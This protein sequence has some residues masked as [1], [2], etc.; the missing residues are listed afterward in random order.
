MAILTN[1]VSIDL[2]VN[3][4][5]NS[6]KSLAGVWLGEGDSCVYEPKGDPRKVD[7]AL[8]ILDNFCKPA[9]FLLGHNIIHFDLPHLENVKK[10]LR[11]LKKPVIDTLWLNPLAFPEHPYHRLVKH[12]QDGR[13]QGDQ[14]N[15][16]ELDARLTLKVLGNQL[17]EFAKLNVKSPYSLIAYHYLATQEVAH[18]GFDAVF[19]HIRET[20]QPNDQET[21]TAA[22]MRLQDKAGRTSKQEAVDSTSVLLQVKSGRPSKQEAVAAITELLQ[23]KACNQQIELAIQ[24]ID[25][26]GWPLAF[27]LAWIS[28]SGGNSVLAPWVLHQFPEA[29]KVIR[30]L[31]D[32]SCND[33]AC[34][35]CGQHNNPNTLLKDWFGFDSFRPMPATNDG[36]PLQ[37][38]ITRDTI[39]KESILG[40]LP[41]GTGKSV[42]YQLPALAQNLKTGALTVVISPLVA[43]MEDQVKG[44]K[45]EGITSC[46]TING[47]LSL[48]ERQ[49]ELEKVMLGDVAILLISPEQLRSPSVRKALKQR[50][51]GYWV[52]DEAHCISKW[53]HDFRPD[54]RY[55][56]RFIKEFASDEIAPVLCLTATAKPE[57]IREITDH[58]QDKLRVGLKLHDGGALREKL[59]FEVVP[60]QEPAKHDTVASY[61]SD[62]LPDHDHS[63]AIVYCSTRKN[64][65]R[66]AAFLKEQGVAADH[67]HAG[68]LPE[69]KRDVQ[70]QFA[71]GVLRVIAATNAF[72]MGINKPDI[73]LVVH[74]DIPASLENYMQEAG[75]A[76]RD[77]EEARC[78]LLFNREDIERQF[79]LTASSKL[80][81]VEISAILKA[82]RQLD[83]KKGKSGEVVATA[84]E[85]VREEKDHEF[86]RDS[87]AHDSRDTIST[88][89]K[90]AVAWLEEAALLQREENITSV[91]PACLSVQTLEEAKTIIE[92][93]AG[94]TD[95]YKRKLKRLVRELINAPKDE[96][97]TTDDLGGRA[98]FEAVALRRAMNDLEALGIATNDT[99]ITIFVHVGVADSSQA[100]LKEFNNMEVSL[101]AKMQELAPDMQVNSKSP[102]M[103]N[104]RVASQALKD[105]GIAKARPDIV[106]R[107]IRGIAAD[108][109]DASDS[110][111]SLQVK[112]INREVMDITLGRS[113]TKLAKTAEIR[114]NACA[115]LLNH[116]EA[117][118]APGQQGKDIQVPTTLGE[119][120]AAISN[121]T[122]LGDIKDPN[123]LMD[124]ALLWLH[125]QQIVTL[126][127]GL[128]VFRPAMTLQLESKNR[129]FKEEDYKPL[130]LHYE[131]QTLHIHVMAAY[132]KR[133]I[134]S[135]PD[136]EKLTQDY[137][138]LSQ[139][140][141]LKKW[142]PTQDKELKRQT[143]P[144]SWR[145]IVESLN[146]KVQQQIVT[147]DRTDTNTLVLAGPGSGKTRVLVH[148]I[149]Y[150]IR[151]KREDPRGILALVYNRH[152]AAE[153]R[154]RLHDLIGDDSRGVDIFTCHGFAMR[155]V[156][157]TFAQ[158][159]DLPMDADFNAIM[160]EAVTL[161]N[162]DGL[163][164]DD[165]E[166]QR[167]TLLQG[168][169]WIL[170]DE[171][172]DIAEQEYNLIAAIAGRT[173]D[174]P[175]LKLSLMAVGDDDQNIYS[176]KGASA[177]Y[178]RRFEEDYLTKQKDREP[179]YL[180]ENYRSTANIIR[181]SNLVIE[182]AIQRMKADHEIKVNK[183]RKRDPSGG[184]LQK[185]DS[186]GKGR[187]QILKDAGDSVGQT[188]LAFD[189]LVRLSKLMPDWDWAKTAVIAREWKYLNPVR[190]LC[191]AR[192]IPV[193]SAG[194]EKLNFWRL[195]ETQTFIKWLKALDSAIVHTSSIQEWIG[196]QPE[197]PWWA[198]L[199]QSIDELTLEFGDIDTDRDQV[200]EWLAEW[201][202]DIRQRQTGLLLLTAH[203]AK[204][205]EFDHVAVLDGGWSTK[206]VTEDR[207]ASRRLYYVAMTRAR[208]SLTL[209]AMQSRHP[210]L[211]NVDDEA[212]LERG[213]PY[214][215][216][217]VAEPNPGTA[218]DYEAKLA[219]CMRLYKTLTPE[220][221]DIGWAGRL[222]S[223]HPSLVAIKQLKPG[224]PLHIEPRDDMWFIT[225][226]FN[227]NV[228]KLARNY[229]YSNN[230]VQA[231]VYA[232]QIRNND[233]GTEDSQYRLERNEWSLVL[234]ELVFRRK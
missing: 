234:P 29:S 30:Q 36:V 52:L 8:T 101:I 194:D 214:S 128:T 150:L 198:L 24:G 39:A 83:Q 106:D 181:A 204:G 166:A 120:L 155:I 169:R 143:T 85:I 108:G 232:I 218:T 191:E 137:F 226:K 131:E 165:A 105:E 57:V 212:F 141:F 40:I 176:F 153:I 114:R 171:Y 93:K 10:G 174:E 102:D 207:D 182:P 178:I 63:G 139:E 200:L 47:M 118:V 154:K 127:K 113:W 44:M 188:I 213:N 27:A 58:F 135:M 97:I 202:R 89:V 104:L 126:G 107:L 1:C 220:N 138:K 6:I 42:C 157:A 67:Y 80:N 111:G 16:P 112:K 203:K 50:E 192:G 184:L 26:Q 75:R 43:L 56:A 94:L 99:D 28:V 129:K 146:N 140:E 98:G 132:A 54:Y 122:T 156:G 100:R 5:D 193:Q 46:A 96:G 123:R 41:T 196:Q 134:E 225:D 163:E 133:G 124:C 4:K 55:V 228:G 90:T 221:V 142:M 208:T 45:K 31:R 9:E 161:L 197:G 53:G 167:D 230:L 158:K 17:A 180:I 22:V 117:L 14:V 224:D 121:D 183:R 187:V 21:E 95:N 229:V 64:A 81:Q 37:E 25:N 51:V 160:G 103:L 162:G 116:L 159:S 175:D 13:I 34:G 136:A 61:I 74:A 149:A 152:A 35:W 70:E 15:D 211:G 68:L 38:I 109:K 84:G 231:R 65:E 219:D 3:P 91:Y 7:A 119:L 179:K 33:E 216:D 115:A 177:E 201:S 86:V 209:L 11:L 110:K 73:R 195:R 92:G 168:Y 48:P 2:E 66:V 164:A 82:I 210:I 172:Q 205:L 12:Y 215:L 49:N 147:D 78:V 170:V 145:N 23:G 88:R 227:N 77:Q 20:G 222:E 62:I 185:L 71:T 189:E 32:T 125:E 130:S 69:R 148:R 76:G 79:N 190:S 223:N 217:R 60:V 87:V 233:L 18:Q 19:T 59:I 151:V 186:V 72:G 199:R 206:D 144:D 173:L